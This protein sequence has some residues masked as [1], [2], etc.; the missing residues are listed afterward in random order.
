MKKK[1]FTIAVGSLA[2]ILATLLV[3]SGTNAQTI[4]TFAGTGAAAFGGDGGAA[5]AA[6]LRTPVCI[7]LDASGNMFIADKVN[8]RIRKIDATGIIT[9]IAG[10]GVAAYG[11]DGGAATAAWL[12]QPT[13]IAVY[14]TNIY[15]SDNGNRRIRKV[16]GSGNIVA[17]AGNGTSGY[18]GDG[19]PATAAAIG[20]PNGIN[21]DAFGNIYFADDANHV[22]RKIDGS[23]GII[24]TVAGYGSIGYSGDGGAATAAQLHTP[25]DIFVDAT[26]NLYIADQGNHRVRK[27]TV[28]GI[29]STVA[30]TGIPGSSGDGGAATA[31]TLRYPT[32]VWLDAD[33]N[34]I[35]CDAG[36]Y[37]LRKVTS[38]GTISTIAGTGTF[39]YSGDGGPATAAELSALG[40]VVN[41]SGVMFIADG[42]NNVVRKI[43]PPPVII[44]GTGVVCQGGTTTLTGSVTGG[45]WSSSNT[46][47]ATVDAAGIITGVAPGTTIITYLA[48]SG[49]DARA[50]T[51]NPLPASISGTTTVCI[52]ATTT[53]SNSTSGGTWASSNTTTASIDAAGTVTG[54]AAGTATITYSLATG[55]FTSA[56]ITV[57]TCAPTVTNQ[58]NRPVSNLLAYPNPSNGTFALRL[59]ENESDFTI[60]MTDILGKAV[61]SMKYQKPE[62]ISCTVPN[63]TPGTYFIK[64]TAGEK[65]YR[66]KMTITN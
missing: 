47:V 60:T 59:P 63:N 42:S 55:C 65:V 39:G 22:V 1:A 10:T 23:T 13:G 56:D 36:N 33:G 54:I 30:G 49:G 64:V 14:G 2:Y 31:A 26:G 48:T 34:L 18:S 7:K 16:N 66:A 50:V 32:A 8:N 25:R 38:S 5:T 58:A 45:T 46:S 19:G 41:S 4:S 43:T 53:L 35:I 3:S 12:S 62:T 57:I 17:T 24:T 21:T 28:A 15:I 20:T 29:I 11:G 44:T 52:S 37:K 40:A 27:V 61:I 51:V 6:Q 9:T